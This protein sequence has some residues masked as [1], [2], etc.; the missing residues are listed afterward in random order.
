MDQQSGR[1]CGNVRIAP[2][3]SKRI[4]CAIG[5]KVAARLVTLPPHGVADST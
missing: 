4:T 3:F 2:R 5:I 1:L